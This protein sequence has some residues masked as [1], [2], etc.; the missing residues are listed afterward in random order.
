MTSG[1]LKTEE[2]EK[3]ESFDDIVSGDDGIIDVPPDGFPPEGS[4]PGPDVPAVV[5]PPDLPSMGCESSRWL[6]GGMTEKKLKKILGKG[7][8]AKHD[9]HEMS[10][11][12][13][14]QQLN[15]DLVDDLR[16]RRKVVEV[17]H[18]KGTGELRRKTRAWLKACRFVTAFTEVNGN[19]GSVLAVLSAKKLK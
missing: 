9:Y 13:T 18:G 14:W 16:N 17:V 4:G 3:E 11:D 19:S 12:E 8:E 10:V 7:V 6:A 1:N 2:D 5:L 15:D